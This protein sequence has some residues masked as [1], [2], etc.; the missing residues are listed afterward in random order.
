MQFKVISLMWHNPYKPLQESIRKEIYRLLS[1]RAPL[2]LVADLEAHIP[3]EKL[4]ASFVKRCFLPQGEVGY[5][6]KANIVT[7]QDLARYWGRAIP[8][9]I[10][11]LFEES[12]SLERRSDYS[13]L[14]P[15]RKA[16]LANASALDPVFPFDILIRPSVVFSQTDEKKHDF[17]TGSSAITVFIHAE[18]NDKLLLEDADSVMFRHALGDKVLGL[19]LRYYLESQYQD[20]RPRI[21]E[22]LMAG[23]PERLVQT[24][25]E[26]TQKAIHRWQFSG[27]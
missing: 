21:V 11:R 5:T 10:E 19:G 1:P 22:T 14:I 7:L 2:V 3:D 17:Q 26:A 25:I 8:F 6:W 23:Q 4:S 15:A 12:M 20:L 24:L 27:I 18:L 16:H 13:F 9:S